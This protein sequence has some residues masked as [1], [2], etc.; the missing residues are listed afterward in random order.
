MKGFGV[1][2]SLVLLA[3]LVSC[4]DGNSQESST[5]GVIEYFEG[6]VTVNGSPAEIGLEVM[7]GDVVVTGLGSNAEIVFGESRIIRAKEN[8]TLV[9]DSETRTFDLASGAL[10][11]VQSK[12]R[13]FSGRKAWRV[14]TPNVAAAVRGTLYYV[15]VENPDSVYFCLCNGRIHLEGENGGENLDFEA[16][17]HK[18]VRYIRN[19][20]GR[21]EMEEAPML[22][23]TDEDMESLAKA[24]D[25]TVDWSKIS[26]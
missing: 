4:S 24:V 1:A 11:V 14:Q 18:A 17:H 22:Y 16:T 7:G 12:G 9:L 2:A 21:V 25:V 5:A 19:S 23:H 15:S 20:E 3:A 8:T 13:L 6:T 10:A 26:K